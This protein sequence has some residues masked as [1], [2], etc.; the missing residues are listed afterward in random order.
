MGTGWGTSEARPLR[1]SHYTLFSFLLSHSLNVDSSLLPVPSPILR[2]LLCCIYQLSPWGSS[3]QAVHWCWGSQV[4]LIQRSEQPN[5][6]SFPSRTLPLPR[7]PVLMALQSS[8]VQGFGASPGLFTPSPNPVYSARRTVPPLA[9]LSRLPI[10][11]A[12]SGSAHYLPGP[13]APLAASAVCA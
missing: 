4:I 13:T 6:I 7:F 10:G 2:Y 1:T 11:L 9:S 8:H 5:T 3:H 12:S